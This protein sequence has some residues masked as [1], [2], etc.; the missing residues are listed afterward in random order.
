MCDL[1]FPLCACYHE[2]HGRLSTASV[3]VVFGSL[4]FAR[5]GSLF[6]AMA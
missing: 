3:L 5:P 1:D 2:D 4:W 6:F